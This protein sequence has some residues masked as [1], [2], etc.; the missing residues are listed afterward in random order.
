VVT[1]SSKVT[2]TEVAVAQDVEVLLFVVVVVL[3]LAVVAAAAV[4]DFELVDPVDML[5]TA[6]S[7]F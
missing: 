1:V 6:R 7:T 2:A 4:V 5:I 3:L